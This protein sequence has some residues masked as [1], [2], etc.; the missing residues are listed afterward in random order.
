MYQSLL[1]LLLGG[2][3]PL[4]Q[5]AAADTSQRTAG[6]YNDATFNASGASPNGGIFSAWLNS[7]PNL[8]PIQRSIFGIQR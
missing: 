5:Q 6:A 8:D 2:A 3:N 4:M 1:P 7:Q